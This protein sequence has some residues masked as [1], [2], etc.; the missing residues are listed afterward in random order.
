MKNIHWLLY[1]VH[2]VSTGFRPP[3]FHSHLD[4]LNQQFL[5]YSDILH[6]YFVWHQQPCNTQSHLNHLFT[7]FWCSVDD[8]Y[9][10]K[11]FELLPCDSLLDIFFGNVR[12]NRFYEIIWPLNLHARKSLTL[13][14]LSLQQISKIIETI[15][16]Q[17]QS[18]GRELTEYR[19]RYNIRLVGEGEG[20]A[21]GQ[22]S[23]S[24]RDSEGGGSKSGTGVL[25]S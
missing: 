11:C 1:L 17:M 6:Q 20:E 9:S 14:F 5:K 12:A 22:S 3:L 23:A 21:Q 10:L 4:L 7:P 24:S 19:E 8:V 15:N 18:K 13:F 2:L 25:V 16:T